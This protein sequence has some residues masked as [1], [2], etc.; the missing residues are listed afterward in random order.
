MANKVSI[1]TTTYTPDR[2]NDLKALLDS[3]LN[4]NNKNFDVFVV[5]EGPN[6]LSESVQQFVREKNCPNVNIT[7]NH[8]SKG[9]SASR[10]MALLQAQGDIVAFVDDDAVLNYDWVDEI[11]ET[12]NKDNSVIGVT[13][14]IIPIWEESSMTWVP[15]EFYWI[16][17]CTGDASKEK[18][19]VRNGYGTNLSFR[20]EA[21]HYAGNFDTRLGVM[22]RGKN[23]WQEPGGEETELSLRITRRTG[24][25]IIFNPKVRVYH[26]V[27]KYRIAWKFIIR[28]AFW[29][30][31]FK[32]LLKRK[33]R[34]ESTGDNVL[35]TEH[36][37]LRRILF[38][39]IP[40]S[41][42]LLLR[43]PGT[44]IRQLALTITVLVCVAAGY[45]KYQIQSGE[46]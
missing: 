27:Y 29:E 37:L 9:A 6:E 21:F 19:E 31:Y 42:C 34:E 24:K 35:S 28:R 8:E 26:K 7:N 33:H 10:N 39:R 43:K 36:N 46:K 30:G 11:I 1:I 17:S 45:C 32:A 5:I 40:R 18:M 23:G 25:R 13:G 14:P 41:L 2:L 4:Q 22:G 15:P 20:K 3:I 38:Y 12:F 44:A 16:F